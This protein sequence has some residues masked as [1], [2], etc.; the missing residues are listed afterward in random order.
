[1]GTKSLEVFRH[2][3]SLTVADQRGLWVLHASIP[4]G[5]VLQD[6]SL[7]HRE[8]GGH[9]ETPALAFH[10]S[11]RDGWWGNVTPGFRTRARELSKRDKLA[12]TIGDLFHW[13]RTWGRER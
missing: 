4:S 13:G 7:G 12:S 10:G 6:L 2:L 5:F 1:M 3:A 8:Q 9:P 11:G